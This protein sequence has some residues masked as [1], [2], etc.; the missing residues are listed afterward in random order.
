MGRSMMLTSA[1]QAKLATLVSDKGGLKMATPND[2]EEFAVEIGLSV[3]IV[4]HH[5]FPIQSLC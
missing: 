3:S 2:W 4:F 5:G 1:Q